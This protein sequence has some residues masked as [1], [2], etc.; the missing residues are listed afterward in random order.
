M[1]KDELKI[2]T[3][4]F[5][6]RIMRLANALPDSMGIVK[7]EADESMYWMELRANK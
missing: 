5:A 1:E 4:E 6:L 2:R 3:K 7:Q